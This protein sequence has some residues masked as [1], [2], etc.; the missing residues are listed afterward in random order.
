[1]FNNLELVGK[2]NH[3]HDHHAEDESS[4]TWRK[5]HHMLSRFFSKRPKQEQL[6]ERNILRGDAPENKV[7]CCG[8]VCTCG[9]VCCGGIGVDVW[10]GVVLVACGVVCG[11]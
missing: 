8:F 10:R 9:V 11:V 5:K 1:M 3:Q 6:I 7:V 2:E 4:S